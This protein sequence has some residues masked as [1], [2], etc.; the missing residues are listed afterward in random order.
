MV[1]VAVKVTEVP[2]QTWLAE[3][4][5]K[6]LTGKF[7]LMVIEPEATTCAHPP[8]AAIVLVTV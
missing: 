5:I 6:I 4:A 8:E 3:A 7:G 2:A 1:G